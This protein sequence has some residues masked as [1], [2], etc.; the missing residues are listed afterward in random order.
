MIR[1][2][3]W[4]QP[5]CCRVEKSRKEPVSVGLADRNYPGYCHLEN[6]SKEPVWMGYT[7]SK[8]SRDV[9]VNDSRMQR[10]VHDE[11]QQ[12]SNTAVASPGCTDLEKS[13]ES[14]N[15]FCLVHPQ[16]PWTSPGPA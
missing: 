1:C 3:H 11:K 2:N 8:L 13:R 12:T 5:G 9:G 7:V 6:S 15:L 10:S 16:G 14:G 4:N